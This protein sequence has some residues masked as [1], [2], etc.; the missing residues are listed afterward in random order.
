MWYLIIDLIHLLIVFIPIYL[1]L[2]PY[3][4]ITRKL[5]W[6]LFCFISVPLLWDLFNNLCPL[7][8]LSKKLGGLANTTTNSGFSEKYLKWL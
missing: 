4:Y 7:T 1:F 2:I 8:V 3:K 6:P 5:I